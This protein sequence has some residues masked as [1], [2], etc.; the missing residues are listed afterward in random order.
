MD[1]PTNVPSL[2]NLISINLPKRDELSLRIVRAII[3]RGDKY[4]WY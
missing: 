3:R 2:L 4:S 1:A